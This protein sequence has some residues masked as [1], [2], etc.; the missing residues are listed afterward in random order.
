MEISYSLAELVLNSL[1]DYAIIATD[2]DGTITRWNHGAEKIVGWHST[3][4]LG[5]KLALIFTPH[6]RSAG[7]PESEM[8]LA[9]QDGR[10]PDER[11]HLH[12]TGEHFWAR[13]AL[14]P[15]EVEGEVVGFV[16]IFTDRT[17]EK[18]SEE[19]L[20]LAL[21]AGA[22]VG[23]WVWDIPND[24][25]TTDARLAQIFSVDPD[26]AAQGLPSEAFTRAI[27]PG[28]YRL[29]VET[30]TQTMQ[31]GGQFRTEFRL[32][33]LGETR[34]VEAIGRID[35]GSDGRSTLC[36]GVLVDVTERKRTQAAL[37]ESEERF[38]LAAEAS[39]I[40]GTWTYDFAVE[41]FYA[42]VH[43]ARLYSIEEQRAVAGIS[44]AEFL[45]V[46]H[47]EDQARVAEEV[48]AA[49]ATAGR[50]SHE[51]RLMP[52]DG[53]TRWVFCLGEIY[54]DESGA[55]S[56]AFGLALDITARKE[57]EAEL[58]A[59][60]E[61]LEQR[62]AA[63]IAARSEIEEAL[64]QSQK[65]EAVGQL[66]GGLAHDF[67][68]LLTGIVG[69][70]EMIGQ[71]IKQGRTEDLERYLDAAVSSA[72]RA[73]ALTHRLLAF[74]RRQ[75]LDPKPTNTNQLVEA[76]KELIKGT[77]GPSVKV[78]TVLAHDLWTTLCDP[79]QLENALLNLVINARDAMPDG[80]TLL[81]E[82]SNVDLADAVAGPWDIPA[83]HYVV[84]CI[85]DT[86]TGMTPDVIQRA[87]DPFF[88]TKPL[89]Q[90]TGLGLSMIYGF[91]KQ[92]GG[93][94]RLH[95]T[96]GEGTTVKLYLPRYSG[97]T[98]PAE[99]VG[100]P[101][102]DLHAAAGET[103]LVVDDE[104]VVRMLVCDV[105]DDLDYAAL[106]APDGAAAMKILEASRRIDLLVTDVG[107]TGNMNGRQLADAARTRRPDLKV[108][109]IT[110]YAEAAVI[111]N[112]QLEPGM[113]VLTKPFS[114]ETL[115]TRIHD[116]IADQC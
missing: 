77:V 106:E 104:A 6:D 103:V 92:S 4:V 32:S 87:F 40:I 115:A 23:S 78:K 37:A 3:E 30:I 69:S 10:A 27:H 2:L 90:G 98:L 95:S 58:R 38:R 49:I 43:F 75:T 48:T 19:R 17:R 31:T 35:I 70:L 114:M 74:S 44:L 5:Q 110:G 8:R 105:L 113:Q 72:D 96:V 46:L 36:S 1:P 52:R 56:K 57:I 28:D 61:T 109:F 24:Q 91:V 68:N 60:N 39:G 64:R 34:W 111:G 66:T 50:F 85:T 107:L 7:K 93:Q 11:W 100:Q 51:Y 12:K 42:D 67:N 83:G 88:T 97:E 14:T 73:A 102:G 94:V 29:F 112:G 81:I 89:G 20:Q 26:V 47:E 86:G 59:V 65:M 63:Q 82:S 62:V 108:L 45:A 16:K 53:K 80:G 21:E 22:V 13:G 71:R 9:L 99:D 55:V 101:A 116:M 25:V 41:K 18:L 84:L 79:P 76:M 33:P 54:R 15:I